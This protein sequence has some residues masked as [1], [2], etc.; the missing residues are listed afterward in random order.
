MDI[1]KTV[2]QYVFGSGCLERLEGVLAGRPDDGPVAYFVDHFFRGHDL[3]GRLPVGNRDRVL[4][5][6]TTDEP[7]T[8]SVD[9]L[10]AEAAD[11][12]DGPTAVVGVGG[13]STL[14]TAKAVSNLLA[15]GGRAADY[16]GWDLVPGP[17]V[18]KVGV[19]TLSGTGAEATRTC[20]MMNR[21][22]HLKLGMNSP[23]TVFDRLL[24]DPD[25][26]LTAPRDQVF[27]T[28]MDTYV[29]CIE[30]LAGRYRHPIADAYSRQALELTR[31]VFLADDMMAPENR[32]RL[33]V[34]SYLGGSAIGNSFVG[35]VHP[36]SAGLSM[37]LG[38][39]HCLA[40]CVVMNVIDDF[41]PDQSAE[42][43]RMAEAQG[44]A[45][46]QG[47][48]ADLT[49]DQHDDLHAATVIHEKPLANALGDGFRDV[50]D[51]D[52]VAE[53]FRRL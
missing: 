52:T 5:V 16:Q 26:M 53:I 34:A 32:E 29:H 44:V 10:T 42:F 7:T 35:V 41:Y 39:H 37:V 31:Q 18:F 13:G 51:R 43:R 24:L 47:L 33:M 2:G 20:V 6:D 15:H 50:L 3:V 25:L 8:D 40:N 12:G 36:L 48:C 28:G 19:P 38:T 46:P 30:S 4:Y 1:T 11:S 9:A 22:N 17:G 21:A 27:F 14:D 49:E 23:H 45:L